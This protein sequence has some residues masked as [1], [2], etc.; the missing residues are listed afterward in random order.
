MITG[1]AYSTTYNVYAVIYDQSGRHTTTS[2]Q[3]VSTLTAVAAIGT[4]GYKNLQ[5]A[6]NAA[7]SNQ[8]VTLLSSTTENVNIA[9]GKVLTINLNG[10][11]LTGIGE[12]LVNNGTLTI[13]GG[14]VKGGGTSK[15][16]VNNKIIT[17]NDGTY[18]AATDNNNQTFWNSQN[19][20]ATIKNGNFSNSG[21]L[22][23]G[24][25]IASSGTLTIENGSNISVSGYWAIHSNGTLTINGGKFTGTQ[26]GVVVSGGT[27]N[28]NYGTII[29]NQDGI[30]LTAGTVTI[31]KGGP[32]NVGPT[33]EGN[34]FG[35]SIYDGYTA[36]INAYGGTIT[37]KNQDGIATIGKGGTI[38]IG[39]GTTCP[40]IKGK[41]WG[42]AVNTSGIGLNLHNCTSYLSGGY[43]PYY[44]KS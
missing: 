19:A 18:T 26:Y 5:S 4:T 8:T 10:N 6:V 2:V 40:T 33:I 17:I 21:G 16:V 34:Q 15:A 13:G 7:T 27:T 35:I 20:Q 12:A 36:N 22:V 38:N 32:S 41:G 29:S 31:N 42:V 23:S 9:S 43:G 44:K 25:A 39:N 37:G 28:I 3:N 24:G 14:T 1:I 30:G 11:T